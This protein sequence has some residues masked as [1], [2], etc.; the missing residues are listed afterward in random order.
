MIKSEKEQL[1][2]MRVN[3][4]QRKHRHHLAGQKQQFPTRTS[5]SFDIRSPVSKRQSVVI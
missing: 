4:R 1:G 2:S 5:I 3:Q